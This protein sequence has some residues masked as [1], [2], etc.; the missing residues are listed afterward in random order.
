MRSSS[1]AR[2]SG[3]S[4]GLA[5]HRPA[6]NARRPRLAR[7]WRPALRR[8]RGTAAPGAPVR[9]GHRAPCAQALARA[10][11]V[12]IEQLL[13]ALEG[14]ARA[15]P[16][17]GTG[18]CGWR[19]VRPIRPHRVRACPPR[20]S[21]RARR[22][23]SRCSE[24]WALRAS[25]ERPLRAGAMRTTTAAAFGGDCG[26]AIE[27]SARTESVRVEASPKACCPWMSTR[28]SPTSRNCVAVAA[29]PLIH[30]RLL[31]WLSMVR[32]SSRVSAG[33]SKPASCS[34]DSS[35][36]GASNSVLISARAAP[37]RTH[38]RVGAGTQQRAAVRR[39]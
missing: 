36:G 29:L 22:S 11:L 38:A 33:V 28:W 31:P 21:A 16:A 19:S 10:A 37:S 3:S 12:A 7:G 24:S 30:A 27:L 9:A 23:R 32:R 17:R 13:R 15:R 2:R 25:G 6:A 18:A 26:V 4:F 14:R 20:R 34:Q 39:P 8:L 1:S 5:Q 35:A